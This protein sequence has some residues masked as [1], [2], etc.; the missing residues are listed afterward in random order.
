M[1]NFFMYSILNYETQPT[2]P[3][4][5]TILSYTL[6]VLID[7]HIIDGIEV[8]SGPTQSSF[9]SNIKIVHNNVC[10]LKSK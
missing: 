10:D 6:L 8:K 2:L 3:N 7:L 1:T 9:L 5:V 4:L